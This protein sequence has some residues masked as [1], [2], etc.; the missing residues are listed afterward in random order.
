MKNRVVFRGELNCLAHGFQHPHLGD[1]PSSKESIIQ[2][3]SFQ[4]TTRQYR[5]SAHDSLPKV[6]IITVNSLSHIHYK[7]PSKVNHS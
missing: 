2:A 6:S 5:I 3:I 7:R 4:S 1:L